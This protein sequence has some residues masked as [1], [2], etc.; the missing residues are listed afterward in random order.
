MKAAIITPD[1]SGRTSAIQE[2]AP[3]SIRG[4]EK[5]PKNEPRSAPHPLCCHSAR[6]VCCHPAYPNCH[7]T[8]SAES[9]NKK[10]IGVFE[11]M[12]CHEEFEERITVDKIDDFLDCPNC[13]EK[14]E[15]HYWRVTG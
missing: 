12:G 9:S 15:I 11:C 6:P 8:S 1:K 5:F 14:G 7:A 13:P 10:V 4:A 3:D 2:C